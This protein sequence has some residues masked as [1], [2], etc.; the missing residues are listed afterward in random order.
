MQ[1]FD[2]SILAPTGQN[3]PMPQGVGQEKMNPGGI[4]ALKG[5]VQVLQRMGMSPEDIVTAILQLAERLDL[6][7][8]EEEIRQVV[9][10]AAPAGGTPE[11]APMG[12]G[13]GGGQAPM[14]GGPNLNMGV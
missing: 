5:S 9:E 1:N 11:Q 6:N 3:T 13:M 14:G 2:M 7:V 8:G 4:E 10:Q 12:G